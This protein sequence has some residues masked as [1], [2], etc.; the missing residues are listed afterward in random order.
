MYFDFYICW[1]V[2]GELETSLIKELI[3]DG[4]IA[5]IQRGFY[6]IK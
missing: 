4:A 1:E 2:Y 3:N 6:A 5:H